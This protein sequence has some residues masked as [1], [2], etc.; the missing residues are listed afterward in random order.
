MV[1]W[2]SLVLLNISLLLILIFR[3]W[4]LWLN[5]QGISWLLVWWWMMY[6]WFCSLCGL[7]GM[8]C[9]VKQLGVVII[10]CCFGGLIGIVIMLC[11]SDLLSWILVLKFLVIRLVN[12]GF[13]YSFMFICGQ[14]VRNEGSVGSIWCLVMMCGRVMCSFLV[15]IVCVLLRFVNVELICFSLFCICL[16]KCVLCL[17]RLIWCVVC[18]S[19][20]MFI[21]VF[22]VCMFCDSVEVEMFSVFVV[23]VKLVWLVM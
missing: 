18:C 13:M 16:R 23:W 6:V 12:V 15:G 2:V 17:V 8:L 14:C 10:I 11:V 4:L 7:V 3:L 19:R 1:L 20:C 9:C 5:F 22:S 21:C